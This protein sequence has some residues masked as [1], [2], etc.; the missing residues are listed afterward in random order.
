MTDF[1]NHMVYSLSLV[2]SRAGQ[3]IN[4]CSKVPGVWWQVR[5]L[6][7]PPLLSDQYLH[8]VSVLYLPDDFIGLQIHTMNI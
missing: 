7:Y 5:A 6:Q 4:K 8:R 2:M 1:S 3:V